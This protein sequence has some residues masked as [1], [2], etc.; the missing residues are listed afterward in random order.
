M[1]SGDLSEIEAIFIDD[2]GVMNDN[3]RRG[4]QYR[5]YIAEYVVPRFGGDHAAWEAANL[6]VIMEQIPLYIDGVGFPVRGGFLD[7]VREMDIAWW[8][9]MCE[10]VGVQASE[11][12]DVCYKIS[13]EVTEF[14]PSTRGRQRRFEPST[15]PDIGSTRRRAR[16]LTISRCGSRG[17]ACRTCSRRRTGRT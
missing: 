11:D 1:T 5:H 16:N 9:G 6:K 2:G 10:I 8:R 7:R 4:Q 13:R 3:E 15:A 12:D 17:W 14:V